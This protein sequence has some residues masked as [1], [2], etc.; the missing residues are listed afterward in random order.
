VAHLLDMTSPSLLNLLN[1][2][3]ALNR[4]IGRIT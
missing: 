1:L 2:A 4:I 3:N